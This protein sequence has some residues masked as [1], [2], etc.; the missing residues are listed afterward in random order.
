MKLYLFEYLNWLDFIILETTIL[1]TSR[2]VDIKQIKWETDKI[3]LVSVRYIRQ[4]IERLREKGILKTTCENPLIVKINQPLYRQTILLYQ[5][6]MGWEEA[7][8]KLIMEKI[9]KEGVI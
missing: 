8:K 6:Y 4:R 9:K 5:A 1:S 3:K 2:K 7:R